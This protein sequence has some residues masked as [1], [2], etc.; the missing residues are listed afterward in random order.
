MMDDFKYDYYINNTA[1][2]IA[3]L[4]LLYADQV[5]LVLNIEPPPPTTFTK[6]ALANS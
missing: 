3:F 2:Y 1:I 4:Q 5:I 6:A